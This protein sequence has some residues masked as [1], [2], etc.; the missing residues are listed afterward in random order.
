MSDSQRSHKREREM[1]TVSTLC[2]IPLLILTY[3]NE[4]EQFVKS[5]RELRVMRWQRQD[6]SSFFI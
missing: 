3:L 5:G 1:K 2:G 4:I 6:L